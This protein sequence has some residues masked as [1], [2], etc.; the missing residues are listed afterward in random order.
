MVWCGT[1]SDGNRYRSRNVP[2]CTTWLA[3]LHQH[4]LATLHS[5]AR[6]ALANE[7]RSKAGKEKKARGC[8]RA[9]APFA[10]SGER[11]ALTATADGRMPCSM[12]AFTRPVRGGHRDF[13]FPASH[14][15]ARRRAVLDSRDGDACSADETRRL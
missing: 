6:L 2:P 11:R 12:E 9:R 13:L 15:E 10:A 1:T 3:P 5:S 7:L 8:R 14:Q 4:S